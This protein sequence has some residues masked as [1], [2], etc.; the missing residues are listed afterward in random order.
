MLHRTDPYPKLGE[1]QILMGVFQRGLRPT[2]SPDCPENIAALIED[3]WVEDPTAV[4][5]FRMDEQ[6]S[7]ESVVVISECL[8]E[9]NINRAAVNE[10]ELHTWAQPNNPVLNVGEEK[11]PGAFMAAA[12]PCPLPVRK[13]N[14]EQAEK[15]EQSS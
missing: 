14:I 7:E 2:V 5:N 9:Q 6:R 4:S 3:C 8:V 10:I 11:K 1:P 15:I 12:P 13:N